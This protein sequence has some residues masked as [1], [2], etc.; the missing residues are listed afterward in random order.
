MK[1]MSRYIIAVAF[2]A[3]MI[4]QAQADTL[5]LSGTVA[6]ASFSGWDDA[7][8]HYDQWYLS[9][10]SST[11]L[12]FTVTVGNEIN[13]TVT[14]DDIVTIPASGIYTAFLLYLQN[15]LDSAGAPFDIGNTFTTTTATD[16]YLGNALVATS[17]LVDSSTSTQVT[18]VGLFPKDLP[19]TFDTV[20]IDFKVTGMFD[21]STNSISPVIFNSAGIQYWLTSPGPTD[22]V[23]EPTSLLLLG[24]GLGWIALAAFRR[25]K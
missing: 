19:I 22:P 23:P 10:P 12:P 25:R 16:F 13:A 5:S 24:T 20:V 14:L 17:G 3:F 21:S 7:G 4:G 8:L 11:S 18:T 6:D 15:P 1:I 2:L 9:L